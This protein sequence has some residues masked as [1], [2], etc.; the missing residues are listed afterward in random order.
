M[1]CKT[2]KT[3][4]IKSLQAVYLLW[5]HIVFG[6]FRFSF[7]ISNHQHVGGLVSHSLCPFVLH[8]DKRLFTLQVRQ[9]VKR[10]DKEVSVG[11]DAVDPLDENN[12]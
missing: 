6:P 9:E 4:F 7:N 2:L 1:I 5:G 3:N 12:V 10:G 11:S 8:G